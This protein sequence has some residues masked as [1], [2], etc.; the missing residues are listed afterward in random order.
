MIQNIDTTNFPKEYKTAL[1]IQ[2]TEWVGQIILD[3]EKQVFQQ[4]LALC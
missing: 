4:H 2:T 1:S 3:L